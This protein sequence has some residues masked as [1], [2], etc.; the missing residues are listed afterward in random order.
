MLFWR[1]WNIVGD[2]FNTNYY[3]DVEH[4]KNFGSSLRRRRRSREE[5]EPVPEHNILRYMDR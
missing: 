4:R 5:R 3:V 1:L 2:A